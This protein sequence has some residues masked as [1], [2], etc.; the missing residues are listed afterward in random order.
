[1]EGRKGVAGRKVTS[2]R[3]CLTLKPSLQSSLTLAS[4]LVVLL[5]VNL[6]QNPLFLPAFEIP[7]RNW[8]DKATGEVRGTSRLWEEPDSRLVKASVKGLLKCRF[9]TQWATMLYS[10]PPT[11]PL[12]PFIYNFVLFWFT[13]CFFHASSYWHPSTESSCESHLSSSKLCI[14]W[15]RPRGLTSEEYLR[16][17][18]KREMWKEHCFEREEDGAD[19]LWL[20]PV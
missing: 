16:D 3:H 5:Y 10:P 8:K 4:A 15:S 13:L 11:P 14:C 20:V 12:Q 19:S 17:I 1:M 2:G 6:K 18:K 7:K 9:E